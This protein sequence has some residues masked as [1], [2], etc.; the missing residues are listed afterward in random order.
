MKFIFNKKAFN[1]LKFV[2]ILVF[3]ENTQPKELILHKHFFKKYNGIW[4][5]DSFY[6]TNQLINILIKLFF[7][8]ENLIPIL[9]KQNHQFSTTSLYKILKKFF[10]KITNVIKF[11]EKTP[12]KDFKYF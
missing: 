9:H 1:L 5:F 11:S 7:S 2:G 10:K 12:S 6:E 3:L 4:G 8:L